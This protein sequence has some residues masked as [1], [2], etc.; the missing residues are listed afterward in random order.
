[1]TA[2]PN[3]RLCVYTYSANG[4]VFYVGM[5]KRERPYH[6]WAGGRGIKW[7]DNVNTVG[8]YKIDVLAWTDDRNEAQRIEREMVASLSPLCNARPGETGEAKQVTSVR[9]SRILALKKAAATYECT[10]N[11]CLGLSLMLG[12]AK[13]DIKRAKAAQCWSTGGLL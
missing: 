5:G 7:F 3:K 12:C 10:V 13:A 4:K 2:I 8:D 6:R 1:M 9:P 11:L